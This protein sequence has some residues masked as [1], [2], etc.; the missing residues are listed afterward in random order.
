MVG[1][2]MKANDWPSHLWIRIT[3]K[4]TIIQFELF[5]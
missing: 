2:N 3:L 1:D 4:G 5:P